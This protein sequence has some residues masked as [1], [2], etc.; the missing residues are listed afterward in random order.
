[1]KVLSFCLK[2]VVLTLAMLGMFACIMQVE[3]AF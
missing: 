2:V 1:M 3:A